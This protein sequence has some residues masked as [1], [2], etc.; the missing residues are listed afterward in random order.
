MDFGG[1][2]QQFY[3]SSVP[4]YATYAWC[5]EIS[6]VT[7]A[8]AC[9]HALNGNHWHRLLEIPAIIGVKSNIT[10]FNY[11]CR[12]CV[13]MFYC[14]RNRFNE[15]K[16]ADMKGVRYRVT[17]AASLD[18]GI[19]RLQ[20]PS[21]RGTTWRNNGRSA[22]NGSR[23]EHIRAFYVDITNIDG[24]KLKMSCYNRD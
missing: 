13:N 7:R 10:T 21:L 6:C 9:H 24:V 1:K 23:F 17:S 11:V 16:H 2:L 8:S 19:V 15:F 5:Q 4:N 12:F 14:G 20:F 18:D 22:W 3:H